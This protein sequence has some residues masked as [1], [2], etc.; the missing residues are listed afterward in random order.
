MTA[1]DLASDPRRLSAPHSLEGVFKPDGAGNA[2]PVT[3]RQRTTA[4]IPVRGPSLSDLD[5]W[6]DADA[7]RHWNRANLDTYWA[8]WLE[9]WRGVEPAEPRV[10]HRSGLQWLVLGVPRLHYTI[11]TLEVTSKT[12]A[13]RYALGMVDRRWHRVIELA[14]ALRAD[15]RAPLPAPV[16]ALHREGAEVSAWLIEDGHRNSFSIAS[17]R[18]AV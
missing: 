10:R 16:D 6:F 13:G 4:T 18:P 3:W 9:W 8:R 1:D 14:M 2:N 17:R 15:Q 12:G 7:L 11:A 5:V